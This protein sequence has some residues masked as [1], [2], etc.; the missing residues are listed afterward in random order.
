MNVTLTLTKMRLKS[1]KALFFVFNRSARGAQILGFKLSVEPPYG[2]L[3]EKLSLFNFMWTNI[4]EH[5]E[6]LVHNI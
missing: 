2:K 4:Y 6:P 1:V 3:F 5:P